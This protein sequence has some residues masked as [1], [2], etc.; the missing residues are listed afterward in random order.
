MSVDLSK[1]KLAELPIQTIVDVTHL[2]ENQ[3]A[4]IQALIDNPNEINT[5]ISIGSMSEA[6]IYN[7]S[8]GDLIGCVKNI[9]F[10][11]RYHH[12]HQVIQI[13]LLFA[14]NKRNKAL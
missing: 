10:A 8:V 11:I 3:Q 13:S 6:E 7:G 5:L 14:G 4:F 2:D 1:I 12:H 9:R